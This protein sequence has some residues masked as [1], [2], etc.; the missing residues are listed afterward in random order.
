MIPDDSATYART[1][2]CPACGFYGSIVFGP[3]L[4]HS[5][6]EVSIGAVLLEAPQGPK[7]AWF[8]DDELAKQLKGAKIKGIT[9][10]KW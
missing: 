1:H 3:D 10:I 6:P 9:L 4:M 7:P 8:V 2:Q 5:V